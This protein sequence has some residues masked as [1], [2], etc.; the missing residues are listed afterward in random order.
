[1]MSG[2]FDCQWTAASADALPLQTR[3]GTCQ[4]SAAALAF[5]DGSN[6]IEIPATLLWWSELPSAAGS[7]NATFTVERLPPEEVVVPAETEKEGGEQED[8]PLLLPP[9]VSSR[10]SANIENRQAL[11]AE[12]YVFAQGLTTNGG[13]NVTL[14]VP[15][16]FLEW[17]AAAVVKSWGRIEYDIDVRVGNVT[18]KDAALVLDALGRPA[19]AF[20]TP[21][22]EEVCGSAAGCAAPETAT[23]DIA[24]LFWRTYVTDNGPATPTL[25]TVNCPGYESVCAEGFP[26]HLYYT[27]TCL[28]YES[29]EV[30]STMLTR[31][32]GT[33]NCAFGGGSDCR[34][35]PHGALC[36]GKYL[37]CP[38]SALLRITLCRCMFRYCCVC[39][40][41]GIAPGHCLGFGVAVRKIQR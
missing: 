29:T 18:V 7:I 13:Q 37:I 17:E 20:A 40:Q 11:Q 4:A 41:A 28:G 12:G 26:S 15:Q 3:T 36:P 22:F 32:E 27:Y 35:C 1:M 5:P 23:K 33:Y 31:P 19:I 21:R 25:T 34:P 9:T 8:T 2:V 16:R 6:V 38:V 39:T 10:T 24:V 14:P 30:C